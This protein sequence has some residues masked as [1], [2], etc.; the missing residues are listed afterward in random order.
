MKKKLNIVVISNS[1]PNNEQAHR[2]V[3]IK[4]T[5]DYLKS[6]VNIR[7]VCPLPWFPSF[8]FFER[9]QKW[10]VFGRISYMYRFENWDVISPKYLSLPK[11]SA[12]LSSLLMLPSVLRAV[13]RLHRAKTIDLLHAHNIFPE[14]V[15]AVVVG[16]IMRIPVII[17]A[18]GTD[19]NEAA[20]SG[21]LRCMQICWALMNADRVTAVSRAL[22]EKISVLA[23][24]IRDVSCISN[25]VNSDVFY[26]KDRVILREKYNI[27]PDKRIFLFVGKFREVKGV[28][29][30][31]QALDLLNKNSDLDFDMVLIGT[32]PL[33]QSYI[34]TVE[35]Y[36]ISE[37]VS[38]LGNLNHRLVS[39]W[40]SV[41]DIFCLPSLN[42]GMP[43]V[44][45]E[46]LSCG[47]PVVATDVGGI[48]DVVSSENGILVPP[49][50]PMRLAD[51]LDSVV[52]KKWSREKVQRTVSNYTWEA[53]TE[54]YYHV[55][56]DVI[57][58]E[59]G[60]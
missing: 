22:C 1:F 56:L 8:K 49:R 52:K 57:G 10:S 23:P 3:Y 12:H 18:R 14:G 31:L 44:V 41:A 7:I 36:G 58:K 29:Y 45:L 19:I 13:R 40:L 2:G 39:E 55:Y 20:S 53:T 34:D 16:K 43:N 42:E 5:V 28:E 47:V 51:A 48:P 54:K 27:N 25:G 21:K 59:A 17:S 24:A 38:F 4:Q 32:G 33:K 11:I 60:H 15:T 37:K 50:N 35:S 30:L 9:F 46:A 26:L 6:F